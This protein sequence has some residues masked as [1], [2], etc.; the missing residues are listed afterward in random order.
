MQ[1]RCSREANGLHLSCKGEN[2]R[3]RHLHQDDL[4]CL[5]LHLEHQHAASAEPVHSQPRCVMQVSACE[6]NV[7]SGFTYLIPSEE[8]LE[9]KIITRGY[10]E[11]KLVVCMAGRLKNSLH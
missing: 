1:S 8:R 11:S 3:R 7:P 2:D 9:A 6:G 5:C 10:L 4:S